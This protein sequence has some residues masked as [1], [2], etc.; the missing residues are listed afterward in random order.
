MIHHDDSW[1]GRWRASATVKAVALPGRR[2]DSEESRAVARR[3]YY[4]SGLSVH[5]ITS[6]T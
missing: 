6:R 2:R 4:M 3:T 1:Y 5:T